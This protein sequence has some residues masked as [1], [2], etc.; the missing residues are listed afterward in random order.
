MK[1]GFSLCW[2]T[3]QVFK[4]LFWPC[5]GPV[6]D[7]NVPQGSFL[8]RQK[9]VNGKILPFGCATAIF[10]K[11]CWTFSKKISFL[12][13]TIFCHIIFFFQSKKGQLMLWR[14]KRHL[15]FVNLQYNML[16]CLNDGTNESSTKRLM[17]QALFFFMISC[18]NLCK[19][20]SNLF[21]YFFYKIAKIKIKSF[22]CPKSIKV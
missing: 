12:Q 4:T 17:F 21:S 9:I 5:T 18:K 14:I 7:C 1:T 11:F 20:P 3:T 15:K 16:G 10:R 8:L 6:R 19:N 13:V 22:E 2:N